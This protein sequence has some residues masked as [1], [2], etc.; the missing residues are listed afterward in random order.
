M[1]KKGADLREVQAVLAHKKIKTTERYTKLTTDD[2]KKI[3][4]KVHPRER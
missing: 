3:L 1:F 2:L 4:K